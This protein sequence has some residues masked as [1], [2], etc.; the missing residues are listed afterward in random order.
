MKIRKKKK[1][2]RKKTTEGG[3]KKRRGD[4]CNRVANKAPKHEREKGMWLKISPKEE[5]SVLP[6][7]SCLT[8]P[9]PSSTPLSTLAALI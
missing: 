6:S 3:E 1:K 2:K 9:T 8:C 5:Y 7:S 4:S